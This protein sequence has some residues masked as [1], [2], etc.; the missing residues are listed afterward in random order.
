MNPSSNLP[1]KSNDSNNTQRQIFEP[2]KH[3]WWIIFG[4]TANGWK[5]LFVMFYSYFSFDNIC[6]YIESHFQ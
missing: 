2:V 1:E 3:L 5:L 6:Q 4:Q